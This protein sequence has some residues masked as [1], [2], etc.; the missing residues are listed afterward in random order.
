MKVEKKYNAD[1]S[2]LKSAF[3]DL[4]KD[5]N[6]FQQFVDSTWVDKYENMMF[7]KYFPIDSLPSTNDPRTGAAVYSITALE[8]QGANNA[9]ARAKGS[10]L[11]S[12]DV[13]GMDIRNGSIRDY[14][15]GWHM[16]GTEKQG[17]DKLAEEIGS[18][19][20]LFKQ[21]VINTDSIIR[22]HYML[23]NEMA[24]QKMS[25]GRFT[26]SAYK[27]FGYDLP[28]TTEYELDAADRDVACGDVAW[29]ADSSATI[30]TDIRNL[31]QD[32]R[33]EK[34]Y[35]GALSLKMTEDF[36]YNVFLKNDE[37]KETVTNFVQLG[38][39]VVPSGAMVTS[40]SYNKWNAAV[41]N[42]IPPIEIINQQSLII[43]SN[44]T[45]N[46]K[47]WKDNIVVLSPAGEQGVTKWAITDEYNTLDGFANIAIATLDGGLLKS[48]NR[49]RIDNSRLPT[50]N[51]EVLGTYEP[52][53]ST[54]NNYWCINASKAND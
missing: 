22:S 35:E 28:V 11:P 23:L 17:F 9:I 40:D 6:I 2:G 47:G 14:G 32:F 45:M 21:Y 38:G 54:W 27:D 50:Y 49:I 19:A 31:V 26:N 10:E 37:V 4:Y 33:D 13:K 48:M 1:D 44:T 53:L 20:P 43:G 18:D 25:T 12:K 42:I 30:L 16:N 3:L 46:V 7:K 41:G 51:T 39:N 29:T 52:V 34:D 5:S 24:A 8:K 36:Y 15:D